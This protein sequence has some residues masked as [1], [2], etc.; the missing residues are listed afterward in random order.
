MLAAD[1]KRRGDMSNENTIMLGLKNAMPA[2]QPCRSMC[3][4]IGKCIL[5][6]AP[7]AG[8]IPQNIPPAIAQNPSV[9]PLA[10]SPAQRT[11]IQ[12][13]V[14]S[15]DT[16]VNFALKE[17]KSTQN[18]EPSIG[19][20]VPGALKLHPLPQPLIYETLPLKRYTYLKFKHQVLIVNPMTRKIVDMFP[21]S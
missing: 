13:A 11:K 3:G 4:C 20:K 18:F 21:E 12:Q 8:A 16:E 1:F 9:P 6:R 17:A 10:L 14:R 7:R 15:E 5:A 19:A 2:P